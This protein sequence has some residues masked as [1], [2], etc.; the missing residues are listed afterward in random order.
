MTGTHEPEKPSHTP[1]RWL[2]AV[3]GGLVA[4]FAG[5]CGVFYAGIG[6]VAGLKGESLGSKFVVLGL[7]YGGVPAS[8]GGLVWWAAVRRRR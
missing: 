2:F 1:L 4:L 6:V 5:G 8:L 7:L 3:V